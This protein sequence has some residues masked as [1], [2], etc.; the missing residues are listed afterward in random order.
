MSDIKNNKVELVLK[1]NNQYFE[2]DDIVTVKL[3][4][5]TILTGRIAKFYPLEDYVCQEFLLD[6]STQFQSITKNIDINDVDTI[7]KI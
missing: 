2:L 6:I 4:N 5:A 3:K 7:A 1:F